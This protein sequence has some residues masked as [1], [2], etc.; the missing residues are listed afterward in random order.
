MYSNDISHIVPLVLENYENGCVCDP[1]QSST[2]DVSFVQKLCQ[3][4][5]LQVRC[6]KINFRP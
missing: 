6:S 3:L 1:L 5:T 4:T 2:Q